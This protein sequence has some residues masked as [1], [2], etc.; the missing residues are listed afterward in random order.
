MVSSA[1]HIVPFLIFLLWFALVIY[2]IVLAT[3]LVN[4]VEQIARLLAQRR[5]E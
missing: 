4:A 3:R 2:V 5:P 1:F